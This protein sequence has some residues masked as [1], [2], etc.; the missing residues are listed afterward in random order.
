MGSLVT[1]QN[2]LTPLDDDERRITKQLVHALVPSGSLIRRD[3]G[4]GLKEAG[5]QLWDLGGNTSTTV[6][7]GRVSAR[8]CWGWG[9]RS[10]RAW[11]VLTL[12][13]DEMGSQYVLQEVLSSN[14][15]S[16]ADYCVPGSRAAAMNETHRVTAPR[17]GNTH[18]QVNDA[19]PNQQLELGT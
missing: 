9:G 3:L 13:P 14:I 1:S 11:R 19:Q 12:T 5:S 18:T 17:E 4:R 2:K 10:P 16:W 6:W 7:Q 8:T 15:C